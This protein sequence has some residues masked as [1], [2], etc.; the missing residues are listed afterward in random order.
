M[1]ESQSATPSVSVIVPVYNISKYVGKCAKSLFEQ[2][3]D[4]LEILFINDGSSDNSVEIIKRVLED[5]PG[6]RILTRVIDMPSNS[7]VAA[8]RL[9]G[10]V[11]SKGDYVI[12]CDGDD[13]VDAD[14]YETLY[15][16]AVT[17][18]ADIVVGDEVM[19]YPD[20]AIPKESLILS[21]SGKEILKNWYRNTIAMVFHNKLVK[22]S[23]YADND[24]LPWKGLNMWED[25]G[26]FA[27][28][29]YH[30]GKVVQAHGPLYHY[31]RGNESAMTARYGDRQIDQMIGIARNISDFFQSKPDAKEFEK[32]AMA[33]QYLAKINLITDSFKNFRK[34]RVLYPESNSIVDDLD[35]K[36]FSLKGRLRFYFVKNGLAPLFI[37]AFKAKNLFLNHNP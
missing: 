6:R 32:T 30:A 33:F 16:C 10:I 15:E 13:W 27:R 4:N 19:E 17:N 3:I 11:E 21:S 5:Y 8:V 18:D 12:H 14:Y 22:R 23:L 37:L 36:A 20:K 24:I 9:R 25:N 35:P 28:L 2:T 31:N 1:F 7:G 29:L 34:F 26:V